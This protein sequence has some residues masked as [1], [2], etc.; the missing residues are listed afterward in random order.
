MASKSRRLRNRAGREAI[1]STAPSRSALVPSCQ[2]QSDADGLAVTHTHIVGYEIA[3]RDSPGQQPTRYV[4]HREGVAVVDRHRLWTVTSPVAKCFC[5]GLPEIEVPSFE[6]TAPRIPWPVL[7][8]A[9]TF[10]RHVYALYQCEA[11][12]WVVY[13]DQAG[14]YRLV[15]PPQ[16]A[17]AAS[18]STDAIPDE[19]AVLAAELHSHPGQMDHHSST[20]DA[21]ECGRLVLSGVVSHLQSWP[22]LTL[23][24]CSPHGEP[25]S[26]PV[27]AVCDVP[28]VSVDLPVLSSGGTRQEAADAVYG[29]PLR[30][31]PDLS[32]EIAKIRRPFLRRGGWLWSMSTPRLT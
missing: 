6:W 1:V 18:V 27:G 11:L 26:V 21:D 31:P 14:S 9:I 19:G 4:L 30:V 24:A 5:P 8:R 12:A 7:R 20:D 17:S 25:V 3:G 28:T 23:R 16:T 15:V 13:D 29:D 2:Q 32:E 22:R 10:F